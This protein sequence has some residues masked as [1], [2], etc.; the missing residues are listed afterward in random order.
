M[1]RMV[2]QRQFRF[3]LD[4]AKHEHREIVEIIKNLKAQRVFSTSIR[5]GIRL[6]WDLRQGN[7]DVLLEEFPWIQDKLGVSVYDLQEQ[8]DR[9]EKQM[10]S[11][12]ISTPSTRPSRPKEDFSHDVDFE[13]TQAKGGDEKPS[14]NML[15]STLGIG[16]KLENLPQEVIR[17]GLERGK[18]PES[19]RQ[20]LSDNNDPRPSEKVD[21]ISSGPKKIAGADIAITAPDL[22]LDGLDDLF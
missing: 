7:T 12:P 11:Q 19:A 20:Y 10:K 13:I 15:I 3:V 17:Y 6:I 5:T 22:E 9:I 8:L 18:L 16:A 14:Y 21:A 2:Q 4:V 1:S